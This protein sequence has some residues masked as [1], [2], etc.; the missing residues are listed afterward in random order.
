MKKLISL[1]L[2][3]CVALGLASCRI[4]D[5]ELQ[6]ETPA[7]I[8]PQVEINLQDETE[9]Q[10][11][12]YEVS[13]EPFEGK[14][15]IITD[16]VDGIMICYLS[17]IPIIAEYG[18]ENI[19]HEK[20]PAIRHTNLDRISRIIDELID[21]SNVKIVIVHWV[22]EITIADFERLREAREDIFRQKW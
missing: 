22:C 13:T 6:I 14:I 15:T 18:E 12:I 3:L 20:W 11:E 16:T 19:I 2:I 21:D 10:E 1:L 8:L 4:S 17:V 5:D 9:C 7:L